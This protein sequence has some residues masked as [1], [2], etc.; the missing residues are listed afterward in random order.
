MTKRSN[1]ANT[2]DALFTPR[3]IACAIIT[4]IGCVVLSFLGYLRP[5]LM[6]VLQGIAEPLPIS[7]SGH[8]LVLP[9]L[10]NWS[11]DV[12][13][14]SLAFSVA[15][16]LGTLVALVI[17]FWSDWMMLL[18]AVPGL[19]TWLVQSAQGQRKPLGTD[20]KVLLCLMIATVPGAVF[21]LLLDDL[22]EATFRSPLLVAVT[23]SVLGLLLYLADKN[24]P[25]ERS[26]D[27]MT[28]RDAIM[29][30]LAQACALIPGV[31]RSGATIT[32]S[33]FFTFDRVS[34]A[35]FSFLMSAPIVA[36]AVVF[37]LPDMLEMSSGEVDLFVVGIVVSAA[38][39]GLAISGL[40]NY[41]RKAS[42]SVFTVYRFALTI[43]VFA[44][45][46]IRGF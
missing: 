4:L 7:S 9:W 24:R 33:R 26:L 6:G 43:L 46:F 41:I 30:G 31:S 22:A 34:A 39:G 32:M 17:Y 29:I 25:Q 27:D 19:L 11:D 20:Q 21:G 23:L 36:G 2:S 37:K 8:L 18:R 28:S 40:L 1:T 44:V 5:V 14:N 42:Y 38:V 12:V 45:Y 13:I 15:L 3:W 10:F 16:H 35:R